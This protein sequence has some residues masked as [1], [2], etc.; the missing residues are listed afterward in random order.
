MVTPALSRA[1]A[2]SRSALHHHLRHPPTSDSLS[3][4]LSEP[5]SLSE[6]LPAI[7]FLLRSGGWKRLRRSHSSSI[8]T[9]TQ[10]LELEKR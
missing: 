3:S 5:E 7:F 2:G 6:S 9:V 10:K 1:G 8:L 4:S